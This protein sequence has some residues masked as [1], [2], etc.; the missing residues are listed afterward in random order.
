MAHFTNLHANG[1]ENIKEGFLDGTR[2]FIIINSKGAF[3]GS[4]VVFGMPAT[5][6]GLTV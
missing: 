1:F 6:R 2:Q 3:S 5:N 4:Q